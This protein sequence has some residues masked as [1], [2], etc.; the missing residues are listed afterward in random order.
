MKSRVERAVKGQ[1][2]RK[3][4]KRGDSYGRG[5]EF[6]VETITSEV[7]KTGRDPRGGGARS[8]LR[9]KAIRE[10]FRLAHP[11]NP[12]PVWWNGIVW[13]LV[14]VG[15]EYATLQA[16]GRWG[17]GA[18]NIAVPKEEIKKVMLR[19]VTADHLY[20]SPDGREVRIAKDDSL[21]NLL[22]STVVAVVEEG[23]LVVF[24]L[25]QDGN[26]RLFWEDHAIDHKPNAEL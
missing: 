7:L 1:K 4:K 24:R 3:G 12:Q 25:S 5:D 16:A 10:Q 22:G 18:P 9:A 20:I 21:S 26:V 6:D 8:R 13:R 14:D 2:P 19:R 17:S 15:K 11:T 23:V